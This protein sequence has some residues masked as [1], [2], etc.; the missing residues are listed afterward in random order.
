MLSVLGDTVR[1]S[2]N[3]IPEEFKEQKGVGLS[4]ELTPALMKL[5]DSNK[6]IILSA[7]NAHLIRIYDF[8]P[9]EKSQA[10]GL[11]ICDDKRI[12]SPVTPEGF[13]KA[14][15]GIPTLPRKR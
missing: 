4:I 7:K 14:I 9:F 1:V 10:P 15:H 11:L 6:T 5:R 2:V 12:M 3:E 8:I 13:A